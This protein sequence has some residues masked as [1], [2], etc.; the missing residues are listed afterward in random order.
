MGGSLRS[1]LSYRMSGLHNMQHFI[2]LTPQHHSVPAGIPN[3]ANQQPC[4]Y[5]L[6]LSANEC[7]SVLFANLCRPLCQIA[8]QA[9]LV[10]WGQWAG[11][12][13]GWRF[14]AWARV[15][16]RCRS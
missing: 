9:L 3:P 4:I 5:I 11:L 6:F 1:L 13:L 7:Q 10:L 16:R 8:R 12:R 15:Q 14:L 2:N